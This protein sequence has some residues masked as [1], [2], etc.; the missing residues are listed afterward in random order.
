MK[1]L[2]NDEIIYIKQGEV[3]YLQ[4]RKLL[5][6]DVR[7]AYGIK[8][9]NYKTVGPNVKK[10]DYEDSINNY[11][12]MCDILGCDINKLVKPEQKHT[13]NVGFVTEIKDMNIEQKYKNTDA[14]ITDCKDIVLATTNADCVI[15]LMYDPIKKVIANVHSGWKG[16]VQQIAKVTVEKM[17]E[18]YNSNP[19]D[20]IC[21]ICP[22]IRKCH[23]EV[24]TPVKE[25]FEVNFKN[26]GRISEIIKY[27]GKKE[28]KCGNLV[29]KW[30]T[31]TVLI[32]KIML[33]NCGL[34]DENII[35]S[36]ICSV[37]NSEKIHSCRIEGKENYGLNSAIIEII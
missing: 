32:N 2:N 31:D 6:Y 1:N 7:H 25:I 37:C 33:E 29:D 13:N 8:P 12:K 15:L 30:L 9:Q 4:F 26:T 27:N 23:F 16:T 19:K 36:G 28:D 17:V 21:C 22:S 34:I 3:E 5:E 10:Q 11:K 20:I 35:D 14:L 18:K 24:E